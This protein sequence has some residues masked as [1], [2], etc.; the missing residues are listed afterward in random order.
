MAQTSGTRARRVATRRGWRKA[1]IIDA[2]AECFME[3]GYHATSVDDVAARL[4]CTKGRIYHYY[5]T[6]T[7]LFFDVHQEGMDRLFAA[8]APALETKGD[9]LTVL[10]AM[11]LAHAQA[12]FAH[13][14]Y[15]NVVAQGV[16][17][18][19]FD[20]TPEHRATL[21]RLIDERDLFE[22]RFKTAIRRAVEDGSLRPVDVS[23]TAKVILGA[24]QWTS[25]W[26]R[27]GEGEDDASRRRLAEKMVDPLI[28]GL[29]RRPPAAAGERVDRLARPA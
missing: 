25:F 19:R 23:V 2:A 28:E 26:Y 22:S 11:C 10:R 16:Q 14:S 13:H 12:M 4:G 6:K 29:R 3:R 17:V 24:L 27:P 21:R 9:G 5:A 8:L 15:E 18:H 7:A 1:E 20:A